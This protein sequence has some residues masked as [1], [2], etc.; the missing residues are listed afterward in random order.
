[1]IVAAFDV[2]VPV[3]IAAFDVDSAS[4]TC[5]L[6]A[7]QVPELVPQY[8]DLSNNLGKVLITPRRDD[9]DVFLCLGY[10]T[11]Q[12]CAWRCGDEITPR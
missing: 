7:R 9:G 4:K 6:S 2:D 8:G 5:H 10:L 3:V 12:P 1:M 11:I